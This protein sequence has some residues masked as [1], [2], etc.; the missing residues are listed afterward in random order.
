MKNLSKVFISVFSLCCLLVVSGM[1]GYAQN[2]SK[3]QII[4]SFEKMSA[5][6]LAVAEAMPEEHYG[7]KPVPEI[8]SFAEQ[9]NHVAGSNYYIGTILKKP[10]RKRL[11]GT[12]K[13]TVVADLKASLEYV[14]TALEGM[15][16]AD[17]NE[18]FDFFTGKITRFQGYLFMLDH[19]THH[20]G[21]QIVYL[22]LKGITPP[23]FTSW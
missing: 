18:E 3:D 11:T 19:M 5:Y 15:N 20:R 10:L 22:R 21:Y 1:D 23:E 13:A 2:L 9:L 8:M 7:F 4:K 12:D 17:F 16:D 14:K 6:T